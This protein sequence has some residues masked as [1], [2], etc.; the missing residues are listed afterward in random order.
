MTEFITRNYGGKNFE[1]CIKTDSKEHYKIAEDFA[2]RL[3]GHAKPMTNIDLLR[4]MSNEKVAY[5]IISNIEEKILQWLQQ[6]I[7]TEN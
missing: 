2:R 5:W 4:I 7:E 3:I 6:P 1:I